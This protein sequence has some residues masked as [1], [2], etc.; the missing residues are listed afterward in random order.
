MKFP[1]AGMSGSPV[2]IDGKS[3]GNNMTAALAKP[4]H[5]EEPRWAA[6]PASPSWVP[7]RKVLICEE[8]ASRDSFDR[9][10]T[11]IASEVGKLAG[12]TP[13]FPSTSNRTRNAILRSK[14]LTCQHLSG[15]GRFSPLV[16]VGTVKAS[17]VAVR[18]YADHLAGSGTKYRRKSE[19]SIRLWAQAAWYL[20][21][22]GVRK[23]LQCKELRANP[24]EG[25]ASRT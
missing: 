4:F 23:A 8:L 16:E 19:T 24:N 1:I 9:T 22:G 25:R 14:M 20:V 3:F 6:L 12:R 10:S 15:V 11:V 7:E 5:M 17:S 13:L 2:Y 18:C 21:D